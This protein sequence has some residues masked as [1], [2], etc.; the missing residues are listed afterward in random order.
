MTLRLQL[1]RR[2]SI[3]QLT[4][5]SRCARI[6]V[7]PQESQPSRIP[8]FEAERH[9]I[10]SLPARCPAIGGI[11]PGCGIEPQT[12]DDGE[13]VAVA[14]INT[15]PFSAAALTETAQIGRAHR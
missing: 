5:P 7:R 2:K 6:D 8:R 13:G 14:R 1:G 12:G 15:D 3:L 11:V 9:P 4:A 10:R